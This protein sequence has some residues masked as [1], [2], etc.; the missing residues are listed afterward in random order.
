MRIISFEVDGQTYFGGMLPCGEQVISFSNPESG[1]PQPC[2]F[3]AWYDTD[4]PSLQAALALYDDLIAAGPG[5]DR[6][7]ALLEKDVILKKEHVCLLAPVPH[8][9]KFL[10]A[11]LN[12]RDHAEE[13]GMAIPKEPMIFSK[14]NTAVT[15]PEAP[16]FLPKSSQKVDYEA[17]LA[18]VIGRRCRRVSKAEAMQ[19]VLG[20]TCVN[21]VSARDL[22][23]SDGQWT[24]AKS[25]DSFGPMG[26]SVVT[27]DELSDAS[28][29]RIQLRLNGE[30]LQDSNTSQMIFNTADLVSFIST[31]ITLYPGDIISTGTPPG[32][33]FARKPPIYL[34][35]GD[36]MEVEIEKIGILRNP[37]KA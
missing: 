5:S 21:D 17:E 27:L 19:Y 10:C 3:E 30:T 33:G 12:Y 4:G 28:N 32:V 9:G 14:L 22:Q 23:E 37:V 13:S 6:H 29:L 36:V 8:P 20:Y 18:I 31:D 34:H 24:R 1:L 7:Q 11:G 16:V 2:Y 35:D 25:L 15:G 26:E